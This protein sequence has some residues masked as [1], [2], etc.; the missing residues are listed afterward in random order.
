MLL[1]KVI[2][3]ALPVF[4]KRRYIL[5]SVVLANE[6]IEDKAKPKKKKEPIRFKIDF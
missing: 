2:Y 1:S 3:E 4:L 5:D 6:L